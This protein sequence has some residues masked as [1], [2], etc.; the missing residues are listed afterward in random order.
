MKTKNYNK[1]SLFMQIITLALLTFVLT[2]SNYM[3]KAEIVET[4]GISEEAT[5]NITEEVT[6]QAR[7]EEPT[8]PDS[9]EIITPSAKILFI[10]N[11]STYYN[12]MPKMVKGLATADGENVDVT[13]ITASGYKLSQ[14]TSVSNVYYAQIISTL[15]NNHWDFV[16]V[17][18]HR[19]VIVENPAKTEK[20][21][22][23]L[24]PYIDAAGAQLVLYETRADYNGR[25]FTLNN[26]SV[27]LDNLTMQY[28]LTRNYYSIGNKFNA[29]VCAAGV[30]YSRSM[31]LYPDIVIYD[32][33]ML[34]PSPYGS[35]LI[36]CSLYETIF[37]KSAFGNA[38]LPDSKYDTDGLLKNLDTESLRKLQNVAD[39][40]L[41]LTQNKVEL[42]KGQSKK[43]TA[44]FNMSKDNSS[45]EG[46]KNIPEYFSL[47]DT[48]VSAN[49]KNGTI[50]ALNTGDTMIMATTDS[51]L[52]A[53]YD[54]S[55]IQPSTSFA[56]AEP[57][58]AKV[59]RKDTFTYT[60]TLLPEDTTDKITWKSSDETVATVD[61]NGTVTA[62]KVG[63]AKITAATD[64]GITLTRSIRVKLATPTKVK[65]KKMSTKA[66][67]KNY[68]NVKITWKKNKNAVCYYVYR[69]T[70]KGSG[71][72]K[73]ATTTT[74]KY[75]DK[76]KK[77]GKTFY[78]KIRSVYSNTKCNS[79][80][81]TGIK[82]KLA[83]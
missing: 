60:T 77:K 80:R 26:T 56:I 65:V 27:F 66:K 79:Y 33:D 42:L 45:L 46:Y 39:A 1:T 31:N 4:T 12:N 63:T 74:A 70:K 17:Q 28:Y 38:F 75:V 73:I 62:K 15:E 10:G 53:M 36:A 16:V 52:I 21:I 64:S 47:N 71:Y 3:V 43:I 68:A 29:L 34:H 32:E 23:I 9:S 50:T 55:V 40:T 25:E 59:H 20:A 51:G 49:K 19:D 72:K 22:S 81:N 69:S 2:A 58:L 76:N 54:V 83:K 7:G 48:I 11:S 78:Y 37:E 35:Y 14:F 30:N 5:T 82:I 44:T 61:E 18:D 57:S 41:K 67:S 13:A 8:T 24:K 6:T